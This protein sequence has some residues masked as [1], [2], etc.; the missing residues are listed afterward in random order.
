MKSWFSQSSNRVPGICIKFTW[1]QRVDDDARKKNEKEEIK[2]MIA[3]MVIVIGIDKAALFN[4][5][6]I[7]TGLNRNRYNKSSPNANLLICKWKMKCVACE[8][9]KNK[10][11]FFADC[12]RISILFRNGKKI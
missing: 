4:V 9:T 7:K 3:V 2:Y 12:K 5:Y 8:K 11:N 10:M 1:V 6:R